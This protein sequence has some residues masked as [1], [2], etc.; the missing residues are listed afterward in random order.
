MNTM[1]ISRRGLLG[2]AVPIGLWAAGARA[3]DKLRMRI[4]CV[5]NAADTI[6]TGTDT[7]SAD[8]PDLN[9]TVYKSTLGQ[10]ELQLYQSVQLGT[11]ESA[12]ATTGTL[13]AFVPEAD[14]FNLPFLFR[15]R[16]H[17]FNV[18]DGEIGNEF[19][20]KAAKKGLRILGWWIDGTRNTS[21][22]MRPVMKPE[23]Y[24]GMKV[25]TMESPPYIAFYKAMGALPVAMPI[26]SVYNALSTGAI[27]GVDGSLSAQLEF[28]HIE[29]LKYAAITDHAILFYPFVVNESWFSGLPAASQQSIVAAEAKARRVQRK[30]DATY[31]DSMEAAW[32]AQGRT[33][34]HP[35]LEAFRKVAEQ[36]YPQFYAA[37][38]GRQMIERVAAVPDKSPG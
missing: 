38:G 32:R 4:A 33:I 9:V 19:N 25:R 28:K 10:G 29:V 34:T 24:K 22:N 8:T 17:A 37:V 12:I 2:T 21:N 18:V 15:N 3:A 31:Q 13:S 35:D 1:L 27:D 36:I 7:F 16:Q 30:A 20:E 11:L 6:Y 5:L 14:L 23:D 26:T